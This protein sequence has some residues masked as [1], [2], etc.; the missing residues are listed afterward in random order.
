[1]NHMLRKP[2][3]EEQPVGVV[4]DNPELFAAHKLLLKS[5]AQFRKNWVGFAEELGFTKPCFCYCGFSDLWVSRCQIKSDNPDFAFY[6]QGL[7]S[8][9]RIA[10]PK[11]RT[12]TELANVRAKWDAACVTH[13]GTTHPN[14]TNQEH[15]FHVLLGRPHALSW[16]ECSAVYAEEDRLVFFGKAHGIT[17]YLETRG[18]EVVQVIDNIHQPL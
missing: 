14:Y 9:L 8:Q 18:F 11:G 4:I 7:G 2:E 5:Q 15:E 12:K 16:P 13:F 1:M 6:R 17:E 10:A 3:P